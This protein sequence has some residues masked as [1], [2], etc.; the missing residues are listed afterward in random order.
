[1]K[2]IK[3]PTHVAFIMD[4]NGRW[5]RRR[6]RPRAFGHRAGVQNMIKV[7]SHAFKLGV[8]IVT[9]YALSSENLSNVK[10]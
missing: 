5:A 4:G 6:F 2:R 8:R 3:L 1:M 7:C 9:V 10:R